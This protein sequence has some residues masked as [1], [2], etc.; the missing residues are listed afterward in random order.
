MGSDGVEESRL[1]LAVAKGLERLNALVT[2]CHVHIDRSLIE[3][4]SSE[5]GGEACRLRGTCALRSLQFWALPFW[6]LF[7][8]R[9]GCMYIT[10]ER[11]TSTFLKPTITE[12]R[13]I[14][15]PR[16]IPTVPSTNGLS[17]L[18]TT[19]IRSCSTARG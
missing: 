15:T 6:G 7:P 17:G 8:S 18:Q 14:S 3:A 12:R 13:I 16:R 4:V 11:P 2:G 9:L 5:S 1:A 19:T 10:K